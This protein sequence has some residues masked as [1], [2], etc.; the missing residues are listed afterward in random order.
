MQLI[1]FSLEALRD[2]QAQTAVSII[3]RHSNEEGGH[4]AVLDVSE[5][6]Q[7]LAPLVLPL[8]LAHAWQSEPNSCEAVRMVAVQV[9]GTHAAIAFVGRQGNFELRDC[10]EINVSN[11]SD[12][13]T[14]CIVPFSVE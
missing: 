4:I 12:I 6:F 14:N 8:Y 5:A 9:K 11:T 2:R 10:H 3:L 13:R 7:I 1:I